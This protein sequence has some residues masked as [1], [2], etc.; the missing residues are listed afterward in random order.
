MTKMP[1]LFVSHG[2]PNVVTDPSLAHDFLRSLSHFVPKPDAIV[3]ASAHFEAPGPSVM[4]DRAPGMIYDFGGFAPELHEMVYAAPGHPALAD[5]VLGLLNAAGF[6]PKAV[7]QRGYDH[8]MWN[9]LIL[10]YPEADIPVVGLSTDP[11]QDAAWHLRAGRALAS[12]RAENVLVIGSGHITHNL[13]EVIGLMRGKPA[14]PGFGQKV[15]AF[16]DWFHEALAAGDER[17]LAGWKS[18]APFVTDNHPTDE[19]LLPLFTA[20]GA[21]GEEATGERIHN[22]TEFDGVF[23]WDAYRFT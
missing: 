9:P 1:T 21:A 18:Q 12:L 20:F 5:K 3:I 14:T 16:T 4:R 7:E 13:R 15:S 8:G 11:N 22:S 6:E 17:A 10:A 19:H 23:A 2:G